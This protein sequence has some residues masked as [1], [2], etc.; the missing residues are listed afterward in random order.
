MWK[1][2][3]ADELGPLKYEA[4]R[5]F[6]QTPG[7]LR[8]EPVQKRMAVW[9]EKHPEELHLILLLWA[10]QQPRPPMLPIIEELS[11]N[12]TL[13]EQL[14]SLIRT[15]GPGAVAASIAVGGDTAL[16]CQLRDIVNDEANL[17]QI[18]QSA[19]LYT[20]DEA[21][22]NIAPIET[23]QDDSE[24]AQFWRAEAEKMRVTLAQMEAQLARARDDLA[25]QASARTKVKSLENEI[26]NLQRRDEKKV[27]NFRQEIG[28]GRT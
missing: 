2:L 28:T 15:F 27:Q 22:E 16:F 13:K 7:S 5:G 9:L 12:S 19:P 8:R 3:S 24:S 21:T 20:S 4:L 17:S 23:P 11:D 18:M 26:A 25:K 1:H 10:H 14:P 6:Q